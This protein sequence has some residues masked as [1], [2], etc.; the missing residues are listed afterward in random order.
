MSQITEEQKAELVEAL[1]NPKAGQTVRP[2]EFAGAVAEF[3]AALKDKGLSK[4]EAME[5]TKVF[6]ESA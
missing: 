1:K 2:S 5:L 6:V 3:Y 4:T